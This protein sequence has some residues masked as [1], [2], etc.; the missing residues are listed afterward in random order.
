MKKRLPIGTQSFSK[1]RREGCV[2]VDKTEHIYKMV[3]TGGS[4]Y[5]LSR[6]RRFGKSLLISTL[7]ELFSGHKE[8]FEGLYIYDKWDWTQQYPVIW[9][10][11]GKRS[12]DSQEELKISLDDFVNAMADKYQL[13]LRERTLNGKFGELIEKIAQSTRKKVVVLVDEYDK[14]IIDHLSNIE[15]LNTN[16]KILHNFY[17]VLKASDKYIRFILLTGVSKFSGLSVFSALNNPDDITLDWKYVS[18]CG[19][20]QEEL[21]YYFTDYIDEVA[22]YENISRDELLDKIRTW[23]NGYSWDGKT[24]VYNPFSTLLLFSKNKFDNYWFRTGTPT[25]LI[26]VLKSRNQI[27]PVLEAIET[28]S[29]AF[30]SYD[31][32]NI[33]EIPLL[34]QTGYLTIKH[35]K[36]IADQEIYT[37]AFPNLEVRNSFFKYLLNAYSNYPP[38][39]I[40]P[41]TFKMQQQIHNGDVSGLQ[42]NLQL[43]LAHIP[44]NLH[45]PKEAYYHSLFLLLMKVLGFDIQGE[46]PTNIGR[47][48]AVWHQPDL[49]VVSEIK[50]H[51]EKDIDTLLQEAMTQ[52]HDRKYY[53]AYLDK[54]VILMA[55]AFT[56]KE[57]K[58]ELNYE[59]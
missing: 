32:V 54:K 23:Y 30:D 11:F 6:P 56:G 21:E 13:T 2:Y 16:K 49:T 15:V 29:S 53:E 51:S 10:D 20:T 3:S 7:D 37:L 19:Y 48:D 46:I 36:R 14:P 43:L 27:K 18:I 33:G 39:Q 4:I 58:C 5:F 52:I 26:E 59:L 50:Y 8:L 1:L 41:L 42:Q 17:S 55:I 25:F 45:I 57:V 22:D 24:A 35:I 34:F 9:L 47:I 44:N 28:D 40:Q 12:F 31:P 38:E